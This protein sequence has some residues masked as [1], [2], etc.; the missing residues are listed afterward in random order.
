MSAYNHADYVGEAIESVLTQSYDNLEFLVT[1]DGSKDR[2]VEEIKKCRDSRIKYIASDINRGAC[3]AINELIIQTK[4]SFVCIINSDDLW[5]DKEKL[6][7]QLKIFSE[8]KNLGAC[9]GLADFVDKNGDDIKKTTVPEGTIFGQENRSRGKWLRHFFLQGNN[10]CHPTVMIKKEC[11]EK[12]GLYNNN[13]RQ[14]PDYEMW[15]RL[16]KKYDIYISE[17]KLTNFRILPGKNASSPTTE[18]LIRDLNEHYIIRKTFF[19]N[20][21]TDILLDGFSSNLITTNINNKLQREIEIALLYFI[22]EGN[23][24]KINTLIGL[25]KISEIMRSEVHAEVA[26][27]EY[28]INAGWL[29]KKSGEVSTIY[30]S[31]IYRNTPPPKNGMSERII[32]SLKLLLN[33]SGKKIF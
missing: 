16:V 6:K 14:I 12:L 23:Y 29:H 26:E 13:Y 5:K 21:E 9:F 32:Q 15:I 25:E 8:H 3:A 30:E 28:G 19:E 11:Y 27:K 7:K 1:D 31:M 2:T 4:G 18:N 33:K 22:T 20:T 17:E 10:L 24:S